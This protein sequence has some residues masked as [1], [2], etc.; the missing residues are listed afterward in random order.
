MKVGY[1]R[2]SSVSQNEERQLVKMQEYGV[3]KIFIE[4]ASGKDISG[5]PELENLLAFVREGDSVYIHDFSRLARSVKDLLNIV[6]KLNQ[7]KVSLISFK[8]SIDTTTSTGKLMLTMIG[9]IYEFERENILE[10]QKE[11]I[12]LAKLENKYKG[13]KPIPFPENWE[14]VY[15]KWKSREL[16]GVEAKRILHLKHSTFY[17]L[18]KIYE[19]TSSNEAI[20]SKR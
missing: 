17:K 11:G 19:S 14:F 3:E 9:A 2:V 8:E 1:V 16:T 6:E 12:L 13:R 5:R 15:K 10:R 7:K 4:K 18:L 20:L